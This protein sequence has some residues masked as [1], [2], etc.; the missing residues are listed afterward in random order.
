LRE[1]MAKKHE[2]VSKFV[3]DRPEMAEIAQ[4]VVERINR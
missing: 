2:K 1:E 4:S 3:F